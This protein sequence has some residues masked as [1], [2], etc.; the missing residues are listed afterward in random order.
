MLCKAENIVP[1]CGYVR[2]G[3]IAL[4]IPPIPPKTS[5]STLPTQ[6]E[7]FTRD[8]H[9]SVHRTVIRDQLNIMN[10]KNLNSYWRM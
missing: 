6:R 5:H 7:A 10:V 2:P 9:K 8:S 4:G 3:V 1:L